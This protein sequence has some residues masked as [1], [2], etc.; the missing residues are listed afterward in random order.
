MKY[1]LRMEVDQ[2]KEGIFLCQKKY[3]NNVFKKFNMKHYKQ[4]SI[5]LTQSERVSYWCQAIHKHDWKRIVSYFHKAKYDVFSKYVFQ[6]HESAKY[7]KAKY[8]CWQ[9]KEYF[10]IL[11]D[12]WIT[13]FGISPL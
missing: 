7:E 10:V 2:R 11:K 9:F 13:E 12:P 6:V 5:P 8:I 4:A 3:A 1:V